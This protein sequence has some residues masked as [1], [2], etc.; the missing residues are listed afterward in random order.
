MYYETNSQRDAIAYQKAIKD[1]NERDEKKER[2][3]AWTSMDQNCIN[4]S[5][6]R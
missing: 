6:K 5:K 2:E 1:A 4:S 3:N